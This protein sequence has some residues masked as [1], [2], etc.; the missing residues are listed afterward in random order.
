MT[1]RE[2]SYALEGYRTQDER[3][4][5]KCATL[6]AYLG[7]HKE[8]TSPK[9]IYDQILGRSDEAEFERLAGIKGVS[10]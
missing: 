9:K 8:P 4:W 10:P 3:G 6:I 2:F 7:W 1:P 5:A